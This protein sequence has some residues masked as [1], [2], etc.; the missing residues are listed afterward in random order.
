[1]MIIRSLIKQSRIFFFASFL[2]SVSVSLSYAIFFSDSFESGD[3]TH[4]ENGVTWGARNAGPGDTMTISSDR[5]HTGTYSAKFHFA[6]GAIGADA[7]SELQFN[8][9]SRKRE[10]Y[11]Q[12][13]IW[14]PADYVVRMDMPNNDKLFYL[15]G[16]I[17]DDSVISGMEFER[18]STY[19]TFSMKTKITGY[20]AYLSCSGSAGVHGKPFTFDKS[21]LGRWVKFTFHDKLDSGA[22]D[23]EFQ[24]W[25]D[26]VLK[27]NNTNLSW[28]GAPC[29][30]GYWLHGY[31]MGWANSG[32]DKP[33]DIYIDDVVFSDTYVGLLKVPYTVRRTTVTP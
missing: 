14:F 31:L 19:P 1:M 32:Y 10:I 12:F 22:G 27:I 23:G 33:T 13:Y 28:V 16:E 4:T 8:L 21:Y 29:S 24:M 3:F 25:V 11:I 6:G 2:L 30:P 9:G 15:W 7:W 5:A 17:Y 26:D 20:P 18:A